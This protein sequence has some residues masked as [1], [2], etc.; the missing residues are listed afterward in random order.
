MCT[1]SIRRLDMDDISNHQRWMY[2]RLM[3][4]RRGLQ[5]AFIDGVDEM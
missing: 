3:P 2:N 4:G 1:Y 5:E